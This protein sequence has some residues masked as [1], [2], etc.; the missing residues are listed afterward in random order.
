M[1]SSGSRPFTGLNRGS[2]ILVGKTR[3][4]GCSAKTTDTFKSAKL[5]PQRTKVVFCIDNASLNPTIDMVH[6]FITDVLGVEV[7]SLHEVKPRRRR[8]DPDGTLRRAYRVCIYRDSADL[9]LAE[10]LWPEH[11]AVFE[12]F[13]K[14]DGAAGHTAN[15]DARSV[16]PLQVGTTSQSQRNV[17]A[18]AGTRDDV[19]AGS[20]LTTDD[21]DNQ[22]IK[23]P[24]SSIALSTVTYSGRPMVTTASNWAD[25]SSAAAIIISGDAGCTGN[26]N[27]NDMD[28][29]VNPNTSPI[30]GHLS[31]AD[32]STDLSCY[33]ETTILQSNSPN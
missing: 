9:F 15:F 19:D 18:T 1:L 3:E 4:L 22:L 8:Y 26:D 32:P 27:D 12:W 17:S 31:D 14:G 7:L 13:F 25:A 21:A 11:V 29:S 10:D 6:K 33:N 20:L 23:S 16:V 5:A 24:V 28:L 30:R 2:R